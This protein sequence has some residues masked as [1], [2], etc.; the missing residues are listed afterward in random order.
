MSGFSLTLNHCKCHGSYVS[1]I[2]LKKPSN[3]NN[4][5]GVDKQSK[6]EGLM[7]K[8]MKDQQVAV[9]RIM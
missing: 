9:Q 5:N 1:K 4:F 2:S 7:W 6:K 3:F 8:R